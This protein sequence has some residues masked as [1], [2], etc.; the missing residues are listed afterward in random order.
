MTLCQFR[1]D[2]S[3]GDLVLTSESAADRGYKALD[4]AADRTSIDD[5][6]T[7]RL[8]TREAVLHVL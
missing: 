6:S 3:F 5:F 7:F 8:E 4:R 1:L 2:E